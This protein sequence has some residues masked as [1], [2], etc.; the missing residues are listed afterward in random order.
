MFDAKLVK[1]AV[2]KGFK[3]AFEINL[4]SAKKSQRDAWQNF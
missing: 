4:N 1:N 2:P 3:K